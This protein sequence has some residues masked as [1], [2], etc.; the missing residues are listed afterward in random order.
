MEP[1]VGGEGEESVLLGVVQPAVAA[2][3][4]EP[5]G[6][7]LR[8]AVEGHRERLPRLRQ[9]LGRGVMRHLGG[10]LGRI[11]LMQRILVR[12]RARAVLGDVTA[13]GA[14]LV[15][16]REEGVLAL[17]AFD[18]GDRL[19]GLLLEV[20]AFVPDAGERVV[21]AFA[22][23]PDDD[24]DG[25]AGALDVERRVM[26]AGAGDEEQGTEVRVGLLL[27][28]DRLTEGTGAEHREVGIA[29][30]RTGV[31]E[32]LDVVARIQGVV[33]FGTGRDVG[34]EALAW[35]LALGEIPER[36]QT[37]GVRHHRDAVLDGLSGGEGE[38]SEEQ[39]GGE[40]EHRGN[41]VKRFKSAKVNACG[42]REGTCGQGDTWTRERQDS[43]GD[44]KPGV[45]LRC[46]G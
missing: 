11:A 39:G 4:V 10:L 15:E 31:P 46:I 3:A 17:A 6:E 34:G 1:G 16:A 12:E 29:G 32:I 24:R 2:L 19:G 33:V 37:R 26:Q 43:K 13:G 36:H 35:G 14:F 9:H 23:G 22:D 40:P 44:R 20:G 45:M 30:V 41:E 18:L 38:G 28:A 5:A 42:A 7:Q 25:L 21:A 8:L 27:D